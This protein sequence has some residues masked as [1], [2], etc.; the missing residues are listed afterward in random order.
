MTRLIHVS[1]CEM[2]PLCVPS[3]LRPAV[4]NPAG[5]LRRRRPGGLGQPG[6]AKPPAGAARPGRVMVMRWADPAAGFRVKCAARTIPGRLARQ[7]KCLW[8]TEPRFKSSPGSYFR[9]I[10]H[11]AAAAAALDARCGCGHDCRCPAID[12]TIELGTHAD[13][14]L[15]ASVII[16]TDVLSAGARVSSLDVGSVEL[17][18]L[19][20]DQLGPVTG[21]GLDVSCLMDVES[22]AQ[23]FAADACLVEKPDE[24]QDQMRVAVN[25]FHLFGEA[26]RLALRSFAPVGDGAGDEDFAIG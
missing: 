6:R 19:R 7:D 15:K 12:L 10:S 26:V 17:F 3:S 13:A 2:L 4:I 8:S 18:R 23:T 22:I 20:L 11:Q 5:Y 16:G 21:G 25:E 24:E 14:D 1:P 9:L